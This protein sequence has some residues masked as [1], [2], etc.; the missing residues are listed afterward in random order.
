M[1]R[2]RNER[3]GSNC[4]GIAEVV[5]AEIAA[6][7]VVIVRAAGAAACGRPVASRGA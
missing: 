5:V 3:D 6:V 2:K 4:K 7:A 1:L